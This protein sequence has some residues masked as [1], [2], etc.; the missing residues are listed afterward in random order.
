MYGVELGTKKIN[1]RKRKLTRE[2]KDKVV[3]LKGGDIDWEMW[4]FIIKLNK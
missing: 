3:F 1:F 2:G 4:R